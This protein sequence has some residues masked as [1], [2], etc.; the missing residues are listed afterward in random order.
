MDDFRKRIEARIAERDET[1]NGVEVRYGLKQG[2]F[3]DI[4][5]RDRAPGLHKIIEICKALES[6]PHKLFPELAELYP[7]DAIELLD[8]YF[9]IQDRKRALQERLKAPSGASGK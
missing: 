6:P 5:D 9:E 3:R 1:R 8:E 7:P 2:Y 4:L